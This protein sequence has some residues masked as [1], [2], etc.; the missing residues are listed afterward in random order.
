MSKKA[1]SKIQQRNVQQH[2]VTAAYLVGFTP[3]NRRDSKLFVYERNSDKVFRSISDEAAK[4]RNYYSIPQNDGGFNDIAD[5]ML[6]D[7]EGKAM[8]ALKKLLAG[9]YKLSQIERAL[10][11]LLIAFQEFRTP[12]ARASF[13]KM[14]VHL[15]QATMQMVA[16]APGYLEHT[17]DELKGKGEVERLV[18][19]AQMRHS[20]EKD[21]LIAR[22]HAGIDTM[23]HMSQTAGHFYTQMRWTVFRPAA[24]E[25]LTSD[26]PVVRR[27]PGFTGGLFGGGITSSTVQVWF[28][29]SKKACLLITHDNERKRKFFELLASR[30]QEADAI[31]AEFPEIEARDISAEHVQAVNEQTILNG[32]RFVFS[33]FQS[34]TIS[35]LFK[36]ECQNYR[37]VV[38]G[39]GA[40]SA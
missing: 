8:P 13:Q 2:F 40:E 5:T 39:L 3:E 11:S 19:A 9:D 21:K 26:A 24:G 36:G 33:P 25:F 18:S 37:I 4:R 29:L 34:D 17:L 30:V 28:P 14:E 10:L 27:D 35:G 38:S 32:D 16:R 20:L 7:L 31:R 23:V 12:W 15:A 6:T 1:K 22:P